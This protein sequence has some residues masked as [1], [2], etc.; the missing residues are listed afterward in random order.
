MTMT[1]MRKIVLNRSPLAKVTPIWIALTVEISAEPTFFQEFVVM[2]QY[3]LSLIIADDS[4]DSMNRPQLIC[5]FTEV[6][7]E[8]KWKFLMAFDI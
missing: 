6:I 1:S 7:K 4:K 2:S 3:Y 5:R 8:I